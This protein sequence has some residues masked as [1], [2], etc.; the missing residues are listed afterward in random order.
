MSR[1][2]KPKAVERPSAMDVVRERKRGIPKMVYAAA[3]IVV[4]L[5]LVVWA[6]S[7]LAHQQSVTV[8]DKSTLVTDVATHGTLVRSVSAQGAFAPERVRVA[9]ATQSGVVNQIFVKPGNLVQP[10][11]VIAQMENPALEAQVTNAQSALQV[12]QANLADAK[13][14]A[15]ASVIGQQTSLADAQ[16]QARTDALQAQSYSSLHKS[17]LLGTLQYQTAQIQAQKSSDDLKNRR[18][19]VSV[20]QADAQ[21]KVAAAQAQVDQAAATLQAAETQLSALTVRAA[22]AGI[23]QSVDID[24]GTSVATNTE[25]AR[26]A[27]TRDLKAVLQ[28]AESDVHAVSNGMLARIDTGNGTIVGRVARIAPAAQNGTVGVDVTFNRPLPEGARPD[29]NVD[30]TI[31]ISKIPD[32]ISIARPAGATDGSTIDLFK[33]VDNGTRAVR[34]RVRLGQGSNDRV[35][36]LSGIASGDTVIV[37]DMSAY[38]DQ[39]VLRLR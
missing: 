5:A 12:A 31:I 38:P 13:Q 26:I 28:V 6:I 27:D 30:G 14:Q 39:P 35:Q 9:S 3:G 11:T 16:A 29:A 22:T 1:V 17:G 32:A 34:V 4:L 36:V 23:V 2:F 37:S 33:V 19:Q 10:G 20:A 21:A 7:S 25:I 24:P 8:V 15:Q 18:A